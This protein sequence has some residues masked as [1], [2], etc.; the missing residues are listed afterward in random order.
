MRFIYV[1]SLF[2]YWKFTEGL[3]IKLEVV[4]MIGRHSLN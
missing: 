2:D 4:K 1:D 3:E